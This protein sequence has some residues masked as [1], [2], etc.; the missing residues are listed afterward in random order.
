MQKIVPCDRLKLTKYVETTTRLL[1]AT[2]R[3][4]VDVS[5]VLKRTETSRICVDYINIISITLIQSILQIHVSEKQAS[6]IQ[7]WYGK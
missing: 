1:R 3:E 4:K 7:S 2:I 5:D 6:W